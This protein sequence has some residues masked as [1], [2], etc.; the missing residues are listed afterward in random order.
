MRANDMTIRAF[1]HRLRRSIASWLDQQQ[2]LRDRRFQA[3]RLEDR[4]L[5][6]ASFALSGAALTV[7][8]F[9]AG[10]SLQISYDPGV[11]PGTETYNLQ[12][13]T[14][15]WEVTDVGGGPF[16]L[17]PDLRTL[18]VGA[19]SLTDL[20]V[21]AS[22][23]ALST[24]TQGTAFS[25]GNLTIL[26][27]GQVQLNNAANDFDQI[28]ITSD[29]V[30]IA[31]ADDLTIS[32]LQT[33]G[34]ATLQPTG[35]LDNTNGAIIHVGGHASF[36]SSQIVLGNHPGDSFH[37]ATLTFQSTGSVEIHSDA[38]VMLSQG[39]SADSLDLSST[40]VV[41]NE[42]GAS[43]QVTQQASFSS[44]SLRL[45]FE[46]GDDI[47]LG[48][49]SSTTTGATEF[50]E[51]DNTLIGTQVHADSAHLISSGKL[52][53]SASSSIHITNNASLEAASL[54]IGFEAGDDV[55]F[56]S[57]S[58]AA[59]GAAEVS[60]DDNTLFEGIVQADSL[61]AVSVGS[62]GNAVNAS[63]QITSHAAF[64][65][66]SLTLGAALGDSMN[67]GTLAATT[68]LA[69]EI[70][71]DSASVIDGTVQADSLK[72]TSTGSITNLANAE[73]K[74]TNNASFNGASVKVGF[75]AGD[76]VHLGSLSAVTTGATEVSEDSSM[77]L[78]GTVQAAS[79]RL[80]SS[81][82]ITNADNSTVDVSGNASLS[83][84][85][86]NLGFAVGDTVQLGSFSA[87]TTGATELSEDSS[88]LIENTVQAGSL[89][90]VSTGSITNAAGATVTV[91]GNASFS[92]TSLN[93]GFAGGDNVQLGSLSANMTGAAELSEDS[94]TLLESTVQAASLRIVSTAAITNA[95]NSGISITGNASFSGASLSVGFAA[96]DTVQ[97][98][99]LSTST[100]G[101]AELSEDSGT[102]LQASVQ[103]NS[104]RIVSTG[105]IANLAN[106]SVSVTGNASFEGTD[107]ILGFEMGDSVALGSFSSN[108]TGAT[109]LSE[110]DATLLASTVQATSLLI[111]SHGAISNAASST[112]DVAGNASFNGASLNL[113]F[114]NNDTVQLGSFSATTTGAAELSENDD[115]L[116][117][118]SVQANSLRIDST[119]SITNAGNSSVNVAGNASFNGTSLN[120]GFASGDSVQL[121][122]FSSNITG[123]SELSEDDGTLM[124]NTVQAG[125]LHIVSTGA[126]TNAANSTVNVTGNASF[127]GTSLNAGF[128]SGDSVQA[129][130]LTANT[131]GATEFSEDSST[132]I[133][134]TVQASSLRLVSSASITNAANSTVSVTGNA[135]FNGTSLN[136]G[137]ASGDTIQLGS[138]SSNTT[139]AAELSEDSSTLIEN[140]VQAGSLRI[141]SSA[142][143]TNAA[144][145]TV[146]VTGNASFNGT[147][148]NIGF[149]TGDNVQLG[150]V[151]SSTTGATELSE[152][153][154]TLIE[155]TV[156][157]SSLRLMST[158]GI[159]NAASST[160]SITGNASFEG[161]S[162]NLGFA[163]N[164]NVLL[165]SFT[166]STTGA[167]E[168]S[169]DHDSLME[170]TIQAGSL[171]VVST[172]AITNAAN[173]TINVT[174]NGSFSGTSIHLGFANSDNVQ[175][176][177]FS[178]NTTGAA[179]LSEDDSTL[180]A[181]TVQA[182]SLRVISSDAISNAANSS[183]NVTNNASFHGTTLN[184]GFANNDNVQL[185]SFSANTTGTTELSEDNSTL[186]ENSVQANSLRIISTGSITNAAS[187]MVNVAGNAVFGGTSLNLGFAAGDT[188]QLGSFSSNTTGA[189]ELSEDSGTLIENTVQAGSLRIVSSGTITNAANST[190][191]VTGNASFNG[192]S[193]NLGFSTNDNVQ[194]GSFSSS[195]TGTTELSEDGSTQ[196]ANTVQATSLRIVSTGAITNA[197]NSV[198]NVAGNASFNGTSLN[199]GFANNDNVQLGSISAN[200]T[201]AAE[202]SEDSSTLIENTLQASS[203]RIISSASIT[204]STG[205]TVSIAGNASFTGSS[206]NLGFANSDNVQLGSV[207]SNTT[208]IT[209]L[210]EDD[211]THFE[212]ST[213]ASSLRVI[214]T[215]AISN[216]ANSTV[217]VSGNASFS[218]TSLNLGFANA[219]NIQLGSFSSSTTGASELSENS[220]TLIE[221]TV[222]AGSLRIVSSASITN[223]AGSTVNVSGNAAFTGTSLNLGFANGDNVQ[224]G[225]FSTNTT[226]AAELSEDDSTL[227]ENTVQA[228]SLRIAS[229][230]SISNAANSTVN[231]AGNSSFTGS[232]LNL[233]FANS[234]SVQ[235]GSFS[236]DMTG[237][238]ELS[239]DSSTLIEN[240]V[241]AS[242][243][244]IVS[245]SAISNAAN[246]AVTV[247]GNAAFT[248]A[249]LNLGFANN[250]NVQLGSFSTNMTG[251]A[252][253]S[254]DSSTLLA[255]TVQANSL[256]VV[257][258]A[259]ISNAANSTVSV[260]GNAS[261]AG[262]SL[263]LGFAN[264]DTVQ[265]GSFS[266]NTTG[267]T[268][269]SENGSTLID[270]TLQSN[271]LRI[272]STGAIT[273]AANSTV[274][275]TGNASLTGASLNLGFSNNDNVQLG[276]FSANM[277]GAAELSEDNATLIENTVQAGSLRIVSTASITN[278]AN[279]N[280]SVTTNASFTGASLNL[281]FA[282]GDN[283]QL[284]SF[285]ANTTGAAEL[286]EDGSTLITNTVQADSLRI[287]S[288]GAITNAA[289]ST[290]SV[291]NNASFTGSSL[292]LGFAN[293]DNVLLGSFSANTTGAAELSE[294][295]STLIT[296]TVQANSLRIVSTGAIT[297]AANS[298][299]SVTNNAS[300]T[301]SSLNLGFAN[302]DNVQLGS[303][304]SNTTGATE[305]FENGDTLL[306]NQLQAGSALI[307]ST[308]NLTNS[309]GLSVNVTNLL[310]LNAA[311]IVLG[312]NPTDSIT[313]GTLHFQSPGAVDFTG[314]SIVLETGN[315]ASSI[316]LQS[317][318]AI[319]AVLDASTT[320]TANTI[321]LTASNGI[322]TSTVRVVMDTD[323]LQTQSG[324]SQFLRLTGA[325]T[326]N[327][328]KSDSG[329]IDIQGTDLIDGNGASVNL[330]A[331][332]GAIQLQL[333]GNAGQVPA[334]V[335]KPGPLDV[336]ETRSQQ[337]SFQTPGNVAIRAMQ[338]V[339][340]G[341]ITG[342]SIWL[343]GDLNINMSSA[344]VT[345]TTLGILGTSGSVTL[346]VTLQAAQELRID[347]GDLLP[348]NGA[349]TL[350][351][352]QLLLKVR[353]SATVQIDVRQLDASSDQN[354]TLLNRRTS[355]ELQ[356][357]DCDLV[358]LS[359]PGGFTELRSVATT[360]S[361]ISQV[362]PITAQQ[363]SRIVANGLLL[364]GQAD[365]LLSNPT[366]DINT[367][368]SQHSGRLTLVD[369]DDL[370]IGT[371]RTTS[372]ITSDDHDVL[373]QTGGGLTLQQGIDAADSDIRLLTSGRIQQT[374]GTILGNHLGIHQQSTSTSHVVLNSANDVNILAAQNDSA[375]D[376]QF[377]DRD[378][379]II[380]SV[381]RQSHGTVLFGGVT[382]LTSAGG[383]INVEATG[384]LTI[385]KSVI[386]GNG[387]ED[388]SSATGETIRLSSV[389]GNLIVDATAGA[390]LI[391]TDENL[392]R[393][394]A[395]TGDRILLIADSDN[396]YNGDLDND[397]I[398]DE[399]DPDMDG[400]TIANSLDPTAD[401]A[402]EGRITLTGD[403]TL[404]S[405]GGVA[406]R[407]GPRPA[408]GQ[409]NTAFFEFISDP[410]PLALDNSS[411]AWN[412]ANAY[413]DAFYAV[414]GA[415][416][417]ENLLVSLDWQDPVNE[418]LVITDTLTQQ[419]A[420]N[421]GVTSPV[422]SD[423]IQQYLVEQGG[424][425]NMI[426]HLYTSLDMTLF[427]TQLRQTTINV[428]MSV[429]QHPSLALTGSWIE[430]TGTTQSVPGRDVASSDNALTGPNTF[431][432]G[433][434]QFRIPT[435]TPAPP[436]L[437]TGGVVAQME[438]LIV[439]AP[440]EVQVALDPPVQA[441]LGGG[442]V[443][444]SAF[445][446]DV[447]FQIRRQFEADQ[448]AE[449][450]IERLTNSRLISSREALEK[451]I[452][453]NP[454]LQDGAGYEIWLI[455][456]TGGR[457]VERPI[458]E[459]EITGGHPGP[460]RDQSS[461]AEG[462]MQLLDL[463]F[464]LPEENA[465][466]E[467]NEKPNAAGESP[468]ASF[469]PEHLLES[470]MTGIEQLQKLASAV[471]E[472]SVR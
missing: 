188:I 275:V 268:E 455:S 466:P 331:A 111:L 174:G 47:R 68:T 467:P 89:K 4:R 396:S 142:S 440:P 457:K 398:P 171:R 443:S 222:Q 358:A 310:D 205:S 113:G 88:T 428:E 405:D 289:N 414:I 144:N 182:N 302:N 228:N 195:T 387:V 120:L 145:S 99:S 95:A 454:E 134:N 13:T 458:V 17:S 436:A 419:I 374:G 355:L 46:V 418:H 256:R 100:T 85:S 328:L 12:L 74:I 276:S 242:S 292:N 191:N 225:S 311:S 18:T 115:S 22:S 198:V 427:Q 45:G 48:R 162:L 209:E 380:D 388:S 230:S 96:G 354:L 127:S 313:T 432:N 40:G 38:A 14:G 294:D 248:G 187:S 179:E 462:Q 373:L 345:A 326:L 255:N 180:L 349:S 102:L 299:V 20:T 229:G 1:I 327:L 320:L 340:V 296:N 379:L 219:D 335:F 51:D 382:G 279:S 181:N 361:L 465:T 206:L 10:D 245:T 383:D 92:G 469:T 78:T 293:G 368:A 200:T 169:E 309:A 406:H 97:L 9:D 103:A 7:D 247:S 460:A 464:E 80:V 94:S 50:W 125:S 365:H 185:G 214:S 217:S 397:T 359:T 77:L 165:G 69:T 164:D 319:T 147:S 177:S 24:V 381:S 175:L 231:V 201:G 452:A 62:I 116:V 260:S 194:L 112:V 323:Q 41:T 237:A 352:D 83:G 472:E 304:T 166:S 424:L 315:Q 344:N 372:G 447:F 61:K 42:T 265:L 357:L 308:G 463:P 433:R 266:S 137:F 262:T 190:V 82:S 155:N 468:Q 104:L 93:L 238:A 407:F 26:S 70:S 208:G 409:L 79:I 52:T 59:T 305:L 376:I 132:L 346:P 71:E 404:R 459:F 394:N 202:L 25:T 60:E 90:I 312:N 450:V 451:F 367:L 121:G 199:L 337:L 8:G 211:S 67:F 241:Q 408:V 154:S 196:I 297:N 213:Q 153:S 43:L 212:G 393:S 170:N 330:D 252:E 254:E 176:G 356:D 114:A 227:L 84:S 234:D 442:A 148:L 32:N 333:S 392:L 123:A 391:S 334:D 159:S 146:N 233:G 291:T 449:V 453:Q 412:N 251:A 56:G 300:F 295:S 283:I 72:L 49:L 3:V 371:V 413:I 401:G 29:S 270:N 215:G 150:S 445:S 30:D 157:A 16:A 124:Q 184:L 6:D 324:A 58:I 417:E 448:P 11:G 193:L 136:L 314:N 281:G 377:R 375:G 36:Q 389:D 131:T 118:G 66:A 441:E 126:I 110:N 362:L 218:G 415:N 34:D 152:D 386:S 156:Q 207:S 288:T 221:N 106:T 130:S 140:T 101:A 263:N 33:T 27:G 316:Q 235:L 108:T 5:P 107:V 399:L 298:T 244:R 239:E 338:N 378:D 272:V 220:S 249:S 57:L 15:I 261:F 44:A 470:L 400:D 278:A 197:A 258:S 422:S 81:S 232:S 98:G 55:R 267:A 149:A 341:T 143:I 336:I 426:G 246:A 277:T 286:S 172:G 429:S 23:N 173:S 189:S 423:R 35:A 135:S 167:S 342:R 321:D 273:N 364:T 347:A 353:N 86:V 139:G 425:R 224:L 161:T 350:I 117:E 37:S 403:V 259:T 385:L 64:E 178:A 109:E 204:N 75:E 168:L 348:T 446:T 264:N 105:T 351:A 271:S 119:G 39:S 2:R 243:L 438:R 366:N 210:S 317:R 141:V 456:E 402:T 186:I 339:S 21:D 236:A 287:V 439:P 31:D 444:G 269:L 322:G 325:T 274:S 192:T 282:S 133:E 437:F 203:L 226:G 216:A 54:T 138:F 306:A 290:V 91:S 411:A 151:S 390:I 284:G 431:E 240:T 395:E 329:S 420:Q 303:F 158:G 73:L 369:V 280:V 435:V 332:S 223:A 160:V 163:N 53:N 434:A 461:D 122:S 63:V 128:A 410:L 370:T 471:G 416:G 183:V 257:S 65:A 430:Q 285:S 253:L 360:R 301:G 307:R 384:D 28:A 87:N 421:L 19:A 343:T 363:N 318:A 250:D 76:S 129:G